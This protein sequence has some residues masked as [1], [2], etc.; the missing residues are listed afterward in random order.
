[1]IVLKY[2]LIRT[3]TLSLREGVIILSGWE[4]SVFSRLNHL[5]SICVQILHLN[6][7]RRLDYICFSNK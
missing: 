3:I 5:C 6:Q 4:Y 2:Q 7:F 1:M